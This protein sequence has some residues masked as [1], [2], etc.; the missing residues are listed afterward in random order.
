[1]YL[2]Q[3]LKL[4]GQIILLS[5][6][7]LTTVLFAQQGSAKAG[8]GSHIDNEDF[9]NVNENRFPLILSDAK[10]LFS[11]A[12]IADHH[13]DSLE[14]LYVL[15]KIV[16]LLTEAEQLGDMSEDDQ[17][18]YSRFEETL[19]HTYQNNFITIDET[20]SSIATA[21]LKEELSRYLDPIEI[22]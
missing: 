3:Y 15:D 4:E 17:E 18:E 7:L 10:S 9:V 21:S 8:N 5:L 20:S 2:K 16:E 11:E 6:L 1:M 22:E 19:I 13:G 12:I 14:V